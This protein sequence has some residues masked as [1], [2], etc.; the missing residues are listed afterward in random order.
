M[1]SKE[2]NLSAIEARLRTEPSKLR[3]EIVRDIGRFT[4]AL[5][6]VSRSSEG[7]HLQLARTGTLV[8][9][10][11]SH[12]IL[13]AAHVWERV[14][15]HSQKVGITLR[16]NTD[17]QF[18][19][20]TSVITASGPSIPD[21][22][23]EWGPDLAFL[24]VPRERVGAIEAYGRVNFYNL[25]RE[26]QA[27][28]AGDHL[29]IWVL[30]GAPAAFAESTQTHTDLQFTG[31]FS[32]IEKYQ[33]RGELD[34]FDLSTDVTLPGIPQH[35]GGVSGGGLWKILIS[36]TTSPEQISWLAVLQ[37]VAFWQSSQVNGHRIIRCH[38]P[39]SISAAL[40][41]AMPSA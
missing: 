1:A 41:P 15:K 17:H 18:L 26:R 2:N 29:E 24:R 38:G 10:S 30:M 20:E 23:G 35:F 28:P 34:Y 37:G 7:D 12:Y 33:V 5:F 11:G 6:G 21:E 32:H 36:G 19:M 3:E 25:T 40:P 31:Q 4:V 16:E 27:T 22:W 13:T 9:V 39:R 14:L 8:T